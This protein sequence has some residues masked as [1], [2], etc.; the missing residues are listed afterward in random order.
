RILGTIRDVTK[1]RKIEAELRESAKHQGELAAIVANSD[2]VIVSKDLNGIITSWN[3]AATRLFG[4]SPEE[5]IGTSIL[6]LIPEHLHSDEKT[7]IE[8]IRA[9]RRVEHFQ[10]V[11]LAT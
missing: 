8:N 6:R 11:R 4:Y 7:I 3:D 1:I 5:I 2:D 10:T 9:G